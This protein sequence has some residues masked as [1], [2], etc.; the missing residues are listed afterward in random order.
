MNI[1]KI[2]VG[3][4]EIIEVRV[5]K[6]YNKHSFTK[7]SHVKLFEKY[8]KFYIRSCEY[9]GEY[10]PIE[11]ENQFGREFLKRLIRKNISVFIT[12]ID[13][14]KETLILG[15]KSFTADKIADFDFAINDNFIAKVKKKIRIGNLDNAINRLNKKFIIK[16]EEDYN[17]V[18]MGINIHC[19]TDEKIKNFVLAGENSYAFINMVNENGNNIFMVND[20]RTRIKKEEYSFYLIKGKLQFTDN[21]ELAKATKETLICIKQIGSSIDS[22][23]NS[24]NEYGKLEQKKAFDKVKSAGILKYSNIEYDIDKLSL[25]LDIENTKALKK[26]AEVVEKESTL[27]ILKDNP[28]ELLYGE[29]NV[30]SYKKFI[31]GK[32]KET[33]KLKFDIDINSGRI[34]IQSKNDNK[35]KDDFNQGYV[36]Y[37]LDGFVSIFA[38]RENARNNIVTAKCEM[39]HLATILEGK[40]INS[41]KKTKINPLSID[42]R[43]EIFNVKPPTEKQKEAIEIALNTPDIAVIQGPPGTGKTTVIRAI[44][45]R[46]NEISSSS[47]D[48]FAQNLIS[49]FQHDAVENAVDRV[50]ILGLPAVKIGNKNKKEDDSIEVMETKIRNWIVEKAS[51]LR[52]KHLDIIEDD[53]IKRFNNICKSYMLSSNTIDNT[54]KLLNEIKKIVLKRLDIS[55]INKIDD[56]IREL[57]FN[58]NYEYDDREELI[59]YILRIRYTKVSYEDDGHDRIKE[60]LIKLRNSSF[61]E[62]FIK[63]I[64]AL[65]RILREYCGDEKQLSILK[66]IRKNLLIKTIGVE[67][68]FSRPKQNEDIL[69]LLSEIKKELHEKYEKTVDSQDMIIK[70]YIDNFEDNP[71]FIRDSIM[72]YISVLG[73]TNQQSVSN[74]ISKLKGKKISYNNVLIDEA[75]RSNPLDLFIPMSLAKDR[76]I[77]VGDHRQLPHIV[78]EDI[79]EDIEKNT[80]NLNESIKDR[81]RDNIKNSMFEKLFITLKQL[82]KKDN[83]KRTITLDTQYRM[84]PVLGEFIS[85]NFYENHNESQI[86]SGLKA[87]MFKHN[88]DGLEN[89]ACVWMDVPI[90]Q[91]KEI[92]GISKSRTIEAKYIAKHIKKIIDSEHTSDLSFGI[93][94]FYSKQVEEIYKELCNVKIAVRNDNGTYE[95]MY[96]YKYG[97]KSGKQFEKLRIGTVDA[98]QGMEFDVVYLSMVRSNTYPSI[99]EADRRRKYGHLMVENRLCVSMSRQKKMLIVAG[100]SKM[101]NDENENKAIKPLINFYKL[102]NKEGKYGAII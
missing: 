29:L 33:V 24:W 80:Q 4:S 68:I 87:N 10:I 6:S 44:L 77:L 36:I 93:I 39:T 84:H 62:K 11:A 31:K 102:C 2:E 56:L 41:P 43:E 82:E 67:D 71:F 9:N 16:G 57:K 21:T 63:E 72:N 49:A 79:I 101:L 69:V 27:T 92:P 98:F 14:S 1:M 97:N 64:E 83:I 73:A 95:L 42:V 18:I 78:D 30:L 65:K 15:V 12:I 45:Q 35:I 90:E 5:L 75:A 58:R 59:E 8:N 7:D 47:E 88:V 51:L 40:S 52:E 34:Y 20:I 3:K 13:N 70:E 32:E 86:H 23:L 37:S 100:D 55:V 81:I 74:K 99:T 91:G 22:Y 54:I 94:T 19:N 25:R 61:K 85:K 46:L 17:Y 50:N 60:V 53:Y 28:Y 76:I 66:K 48:I 26:F 89:K 38:R 96:K